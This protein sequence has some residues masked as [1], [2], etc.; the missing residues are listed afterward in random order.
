MD[1]LPRSRS[2]RRLYSGGSNNT[3]VPT[4]GSIAQMMGKAAHQHHSHQQQFSSS[5]A[6]A[7]LHPSLI[8]KYRKP[9]QNLADA[10]AQGEWANKRWVWVTDSV[11]GYVA[12]WIVSE[13]NDTVHVACVDDKVR[14]TF[15]L[16]FRLRT[17]CLCSAR[18][19]VD[20]DADSTKPKLYGI[21]TR[22]VPT[23]DISKMNPPKVCN[24]SYADVLAWHLWSPQ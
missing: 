17:S 12:G 10:A 16:P 18:I 14:S 7:E 11:L 21:Q 2:L 24:Q 6:H 4:R 20:I 9:G 19:D 15:L 23:N 13:E 5:A 3:T 1:S 22:T 8:V